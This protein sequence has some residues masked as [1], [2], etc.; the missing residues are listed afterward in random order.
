VFESTVAIYN[1]K[2]V[3]RGANELPLIHVY[4]KSNLMFDCNRIGFKIASIKSV[5]LNNITKRGWL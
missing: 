2:I 3:D 4:M 1:G 5:T